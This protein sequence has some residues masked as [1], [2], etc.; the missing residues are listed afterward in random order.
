MTRPFAK[1]GL[2]GTLLESIVYGLYLTVF[3]Q[4]LRIL[5]RKIVPGFVFAYLATTTLVLFVLITMRL[6]VD[7]HIMTQ[8]LTV[9][10]NG[11]IPNAL[12][13]QKIS[14]G[15]YVSLTII[16]DIFIVYR[17]FAVWSRSLVASAIPCS[18][19]VAGIVSGGLLVSSLG[20]FGPDEPRGLFTIFYC[21]TLVLNVLCTIL[22]ASKLYI[23]D[24]QT[25]LSSSLK[26][27][28]TSIIVIESAALYSACVIIIVVC[29]VLGADD[30]NLVFLL[31]IPSIIGLTFSLIIVRVVGSSATSN[32]TFT[33]IDIN[34][35]S[36]LLFS[37]QLRT[38]GGTEIE[39][40]AC[41]N[42]QSSEKPSVATVPAATAQIR[43]S[44]CFPTADD[45][46]NQLTVRDTSG[47]RQ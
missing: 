6:A 19:I 7:I 46:E 27:K 11:P 40:G 4:T 25:T 14:C 26:L 17:V 37:R 13:L 2:I 34:R 3:L 30:V 29:N 28:W 31:A 1:A 47:H 23:S 42:G 5:R 38:V 15:T 35:S 18:L 9:T 45:V 22:I 12:G 33:S 39:M 36:V 10:G 21:I 44:P 24:R 32:K 16:A 41:L 43:S 8:T 20:N